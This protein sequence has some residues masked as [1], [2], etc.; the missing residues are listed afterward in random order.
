MTHEF[1]PTLTHA[2]ERDID[3]LL[4]EEFYASPS[5]VAWVCKKVGLLNQVASSSVLHSKR[6]TRSRREIDI[7]VEV[8]FKCGDM[9]ALLVEN[10]LDATE[11]PDQAESYRE[12]L[13]MLSDHFAHRVMILVC[14]TVYRQS[15]QGFADK[16]D[17][18]ITYEILAEYFRDQS[19]LGGSEKSRM[20][21]RG[22]LIEQAINKSRRGY[23]SIPNA[24]IGTFNSRY[25]ELLTEIAPSIYAGPS[26]LKEASPDESVS[27]IFDHAK[28]FSALPHAIRPKRFSHECGRG[29][30]NRAN[31]VA[32]AFA[33]W[34]AALKQVRESFEAD[35]S[36]IEATFTAASPSKLRPNPALIMSC[37]TTAI[38]NQGDFEAQKPAIIDGIRAA[39]KLQNW[40]I[41]NQR[42]LW[43]WKEQVEKAMKL[44]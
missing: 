36:A 17:T 14:P 6:R 42:L 25:I 22:E 28:S 23:A 30:T 24:K 21:F 37:K 15:H 33:C 27:M 12:E 35:S 18:V 26:M 11:Q 19:A 1:I 7:F 44:T 16:F 2:T 20:R 3:L 13:T 43:D 39:A 38:N 40:L 32:V 34:G 8:A 10:K 4:V 9:L 41:D 31:Y 29:Q 5:F